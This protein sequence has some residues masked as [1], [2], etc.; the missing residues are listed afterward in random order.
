MKTSKAES[1]N[2]E[3]SKSEEVVLKPRHH[4]SKGK[5]NRAPGKDRFRHIGPVDSHIQGKLIIFLCSDLSIERNP[6]EKLP[7]SNEESKQKKDFSFH[8]EKKGKVSRKKKEV[9][10]DEDGFIQEAKEVIESKP[11]PPPE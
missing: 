8:E 10:E 1:S 7:E 4:G 2:Q 5:V 9:K 6:E 11:Q 3:S